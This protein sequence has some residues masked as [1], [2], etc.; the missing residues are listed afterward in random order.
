MET[1]ILKLL[2]ERYFLDHE[3]T[4]EDIAKRVSAIY[5]PSF[6]VINEMKFIPSTPTLLHANTNGLKKGTLSSCFTMGIDD[7]IEGIFEAAKEA[8]IVTK[9]GGGVGYNFSVLRGNGEHIKSINAK[10]SGPIPFINVFNATLDGIRQGGKRLGAGMGMLDIRHPNILEY[11]RA[12][13]NKGF[14]ERFNLSIRI[15]D[16]FYEKLKNTP[17]APHYVKQKNGLEYVLEDN[18]KQV[19]VKKLWDEIVEYAWLCAEPGIFNLDIATR[20][21]TVTDNVDDVLSNPCSEYVNIPYSSCNLGSINLSKMVKYDSKGKLVFDWYGFFDTIKIATRFLN[22]VVDVN[23]FPLKKIEEVTKQVRPIGL[24]C[25]GFAHL[26]YKLGIPFNSEEAKKL[27]AT[28]FSCLTITS[29]KESMH[30][31]A[32]TKVVYP[33]FDYDMFMKANERFFDGSQFESV[34]DIEGMA[35][36]AAKIKTYGITNSCF[37]S[38]APT[39]SISYLANTSGG[40]EP[41]FALT[42]ARKIEKE[43]KVYEHVFISDPIFDE[44]LNNNFDQETKAKILL[45]VANNKGSCQTVEE[46]PE[47]DRKVFVVASDLTP[48]EHLESLAIVAKRTSLSVS[49]TVNLD[50]DATRE[51][52]SEVYIKAHEM[53]VIGITVYRDGCREGVLV[54]NV[55]K[56]MIQH[57]VKNNAPKR[58]K[59]LP[60]H[61]YRV[62]ILNRATEESERWIIFVGLLNGDPYEIIAGKINGKDFSHDITE[63]EMVKSKKDGKKVYQFVHNGEIIVDDVCGTFLNE[64]REYITRLMSLALRHGCSIEYLQEVLQKS[65][66]TV[67]D[68]NRA[69]VRAI[70]KYIK[71]VKSKE[72]CPVCNEE[73]IYVE[74]CVKCSSPTCS[75]T[76]CS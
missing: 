26:L 2:R 11:I 9:N 10:S 1:Q 75:F 59:T 44:Y 49:K 45:Q 13:N 29:M 7:S 34:D 43:N 73:L 57:I 24:G 55:D 8:A 35:D 20:Q 21:C 28:I 48:I 25:M 51:Q 18:G 71:D 60:S 46:I 6:D 33:L 66:G 47:N 36:L 76:K 63:G 15:P 50:S 64:L 17:N 41:V 38:I 69:I 68:F 37:T 19:T 72:K 27:T 14:L 4:W 65:N 61:V 53:G 3:N 39:G 16:D 67:V 62:N 42:F 22:N 52:I 40:I 32:E 23:D 74:A 5:Q 70:S 58:P 56:E 54:H 30:I 12:K 31:A